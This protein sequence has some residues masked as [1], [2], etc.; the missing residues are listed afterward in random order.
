MQGQGLV[1]SLWETL[2]EEGGR[3]GPILRPVRSFWIETRRHAS[4]AMPVAWQTKPVMSKLISP[5][6]ASATM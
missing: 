5:Y 3:T 1:D 6:D 2:D 4:N